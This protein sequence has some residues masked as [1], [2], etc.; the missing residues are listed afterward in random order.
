MALS[1]LVAVAALAPVPTVQP[2]VLLL[3][4]SAP[5]PRLRATHVHLSE[6]SSPPPAAAASSLPY[7]KLASALA[8]GDAACLVLFAA[9]GRA[10]HA[11]EDG[12]SALAT[13]APFLIAWLAAAPPLG[14]YR[15]RD[16][17]ASAALIPL[18]A[19]AVAVPAGCAAR[20]LLQGYMP[21]L[22]F[23]IVSAIAITVL[24][25][26]WRVGYF[27]TIDKTAG[28]IDEFARAIVDDDD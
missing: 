12:G 16:S 17:L 13:A 27:L 20:G 18:P 25:L 2:A 26:I 6:S 10:D 8:V 21:A 4:R 9:I 15:D 23:W 22:P 14:A 7:A 19:I 28:A 24:T 3:R 5:V 1:L 11:R